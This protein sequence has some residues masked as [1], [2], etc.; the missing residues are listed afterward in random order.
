MKKYQLVLVT[1]MMAIVGCTNQQFLEDG[2]TN[3]VSLAAENGFA[4]LIEQARWGD[5]QAFLKLADCYRDG[6]GVKKDFVGMLCMVSQADEFGSIGR[7]KDYLKEMPEGSDFR[8]IFDAIEKFEDNQLEEAKAMSEQLIA[9][10]SSDG[11]TVQGIM[12]LESGDSLRG[13][14]LMEQAASQGSSLAKLILCVPEF[15]GGKTPDMEMLKRLSDDMPFVNIILAKIYMGEDDE[16]LKDE[17]LAAHYFLKADKNACLT[18][19]GAKWLMYYHQYVSKLPLSEKD[20]QR[21]QIL[22]GGIDTPKEMVEVVDTVVV[23]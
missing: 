11:Y 7:M 15:H 19:R 17:S 20:I 14:R 6:K 2:L 21:L 4:A 3:N 9:N 22:A 12:A 1:T 18:K 10:G 8:T 5:G 13:L 16:K 23:E